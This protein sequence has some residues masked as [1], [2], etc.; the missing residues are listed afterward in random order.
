M[1]RKKQDGRIFRFI[2]NHS[3]ATAFNVYLLLYPKGDLADA[4]RI[5]PSILDEVF[6]Y[7]RTVQDLERVGRVYG[8][9]LSKLEPKELAS[10]EL[11]DELVA[12]IREMAQG[13]GSHLQ[14][15]LLPSEAR[16]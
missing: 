12:R 4:A 8:G 7:L 5:D 13:T 16:A 9:G 2:R 6:G 15:Q 14:Y 3:Q 1:G 11:P 10:L